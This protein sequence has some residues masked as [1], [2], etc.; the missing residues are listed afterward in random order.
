MTAH[1]SSDYRRYLGVVTEREVIVLVDVSSSML[2][3]LPEVK[4]ALSLLLKNMPVKMKRSV[5]AMCHHIPGIC[6]ITSYN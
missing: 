6:V 5:S 1:F 3:H 2:S 4:E